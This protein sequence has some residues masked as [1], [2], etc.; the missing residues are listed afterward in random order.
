M[1]ASKLS[2][3]LPNACAT[4]WSSLES[5][6]ARA[7][8]QPSE[9]ATTNAA[10]NGKTCKYRRSLYFMICLLIKCGAVRPRD[11]LRLPSIPGLPSTNP[12]S[13]QLRGGCSDCRRGH[14]EP[15]FFRNE[16]PGARAG[17][18]ADRALQRVTIRIL[19]PHDVDPPL[20]ADDVEALALR[21]EEDVV[22]VFP[23]R[24]L[25]H[26]LSGIDV[27]YEQHPLL[28]QVN[29]EMVDAPLHGRQDYGCN[30]LEHICSLQP[31]GQNKG[32]EWYQ[33]QLAFCFHVVAPFF[34]RMSRSIPGAAP[35]WF[36]F[37]REPC[38]C[39]HRTKDRPG[40]ARP[41][42]RAPRW[43]AGCLRPARRRLRR[44]GA[45]PRNT[46]LRGWRP[47]KGRAR[48]RASTRAPH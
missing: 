36:R 45:R 4:A 28:L 30:R 14:V 12:I 16:E 26:D 3:L 20:S 21:V 13:E 35:G 42:R 34:S 19:L 2:L 15:S 27:I 38:E 22:G 25:R 17:S 7:G 29:P 47:G 10:I 43:S 8:C 32:Q 9:P 44:P 48:A 31:G 24:L 46:G 5:P 33:N 6:S 1:P 11:V 41:L 37:R 23:D 39:R 18:G 40:S